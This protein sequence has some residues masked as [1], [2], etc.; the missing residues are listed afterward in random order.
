LVKQLDDV[1]VPPLIDHVGV[2]LW[3]LA[4]LWKLEFD[5]AMVDAGYPWM[6]E[7]RGAIVGHLRPGGRSQ[8]QLA[9]EL[10]ISKQAVQ[11]HVDELVAE[12][13]V[14][15][16]ADPDDRRGKLVILTSKGA[17]ALADGNDA[18][19]RIEER[20]RETLGTARFDVLMAAL[21]ELGGHGRA[22]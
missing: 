17:Q 22:S 12:G 1:A 8:S 15:R 4:R 13:V 16:M 9:A 19:R 5:A 14:T 20:Y 18:K 21:E 10:G 7:A 6:A 11:Q 2:R 3:R